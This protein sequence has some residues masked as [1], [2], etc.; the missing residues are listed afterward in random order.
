MVR[1]LCQ[2][3]QRP[4]MAAMAVT[5]ARVARQEA[6]AVAQRDRLVL[7]RKEGTLVQVVVVV[8]RAPEAIVLAL[9]LLVVGRQAATEGMAPMAQ[10]AELVAHLVVAQEV[11]AQR[12]KELAA[13]VRAK[14]QGREVVARLTRHLTAH[15]ALVAEA[16]ERD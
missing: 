12:T 2:Q 5:A 4:S 11:T 16:G 7:D 1:L 8:V 14:A 10:G 13:V 9:D 15:T 3:G 6:V